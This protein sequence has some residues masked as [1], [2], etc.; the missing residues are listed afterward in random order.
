MQT[1]QGTSLS[2]KK[3]KDNYRGSLQNAVVGWKM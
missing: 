1:T 3:E 2:V